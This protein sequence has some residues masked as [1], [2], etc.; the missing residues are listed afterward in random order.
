MRSEGARSWAPSLCFLLPQQPE[1]GGRG[2]Q[3]Q[4]GGVGLGPDLPQRLHGRHV[5]R[6]V[7][8]AQGAGGWLVRARVGRA[9]GFFTS[10]CG[11]S[12]PPPPCPALSLSH[13]FSPSLC[14][15]LRL[16]PPSDVSAPPVGPPPRPAHP[17]PPFLPGSG[18]CLRVRYKLL[19]QEEGEY[20]NVPVADAD[21]CNLLQ[22][23]E[24][25]APWLPHGK[26]SPAQPPSV[27][28][29]SFSNAAAG[30]P[31][32][33]LQFPEDPEAPFPCFS[34]EFLPQGLMGI[35]VPMHP[36]GLGAWGPRPPPPGQSPPPSLG[37]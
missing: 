6:R 11:V 25:P 1:A 33:G 5:L 7:G 18:L 16:V 20:Y 15:S 9:A 27:Q 28:S 24:V 34:R 14:L 35:Q 13:S 37:L 3:A 21:N 12:P 23:F 30:C 26:P 4:R 31:L 17:S 29:W 22:K 10:A 32:L 36:C 8:A 2:A 19:N